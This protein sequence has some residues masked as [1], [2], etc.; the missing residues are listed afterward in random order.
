[1]KRKILVIG[2]GGYLGIV[3]VRKLLELGYKVRVLDSFIYGSRAISCLS[4]PLLEIVK[5]D[6]THAEVVTKAINNSDAVIH[7][8]AVVGDPAAKA[9][10]ELTINTNYI[11]SLSIASACKLSGINKFIYASTC[12]VYGIGDEILDEDSPLN[13]VSLYAKTKISSEKG[14]MSIANGEFCP[15][16]MRMSTLYGYSPRMRFDLVVNTMTMTAFTEGVIK[17]FGGNQWRPLLSLSDAADAYIKILEADI[18]VIGGK[19]YNVGSEKQN[20]RI[21]QV[22]EQVAGAIEELTGK[23]VSIRTEKDNQDVRDYKVSFERI[24]RDTGFEAK[25]SINEAVKEIWM[26]LESGEIK[27]PKQ[28]VYYNHY[29]D[30]SEELIG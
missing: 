10:P 23:K 16:I 18:S 4:S 8:A 22:A 7:L 30:S 9:R 20:Y 13:P 15:T 27:D 1:M 25:T 21:S 2:G 17:V 6:I 14:I 11:A 24:R 28:K 12:S 3:L 26:K 19:I 29:F 5:G